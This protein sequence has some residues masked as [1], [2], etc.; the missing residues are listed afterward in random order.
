MYIIDALRLQID[1]LNEKDFYKYLS[2]SVASVTLLVILIFF[3]YY[4]VTNELTERLST[5]NDQREEIRRILTIAKQAKK[6]REQ[7]D[8]I[9]A[10]DESFKIGGYFN[11]LLDSLRLTEKKQAVDYSHIDHIGAYRES[12]LKAKLTDMNMKELSELLYEIEQNKRVYC[13]ELEIT[14]SRKNQG[15][16]DINLTIATL[17]SK[18]SA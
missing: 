9:L 15:T 13:K 2:F 8:S 7:I 4:R 18:A 10:Q 11:V 12:I 1:S 3:R 14:K 6:Q 17:E 5:I 16:L